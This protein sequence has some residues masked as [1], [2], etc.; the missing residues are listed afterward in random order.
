ME[1]ALN[2]AL[3]VVLDSNPGKAINL[4]TFDTK[5]GKLN[6]CLTSVLQAFKLEKRPKN[7]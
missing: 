6:I 1:T 7:S 5:K 4:I 2:D 3:N